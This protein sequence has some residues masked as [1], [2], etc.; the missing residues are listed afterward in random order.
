MTEKQ[1]NLIV[2]SITGIVFLAVM[3]CGILSLNTSPLAFAALFALITGLSVREFCDIVSERPDV[4]V[5]PFI[6]SVSGVCLFLAV[7]GY[8]M[9]LVTHM[10]VF[11]P[12]IISITYLLISEL[13]LQRE[14]PINNWAYTMMSQ[15]YVALPFALLPVLATLTTGEH[16]WLFPLSVFIFLW[17]SDTGAYCFGSLFGRHR[18]FERISPKKSWEGSIGG[19]IFCIIA[20]VIL[21]HFFPILNSWEWIGFALVVVVF[22]TWGDLC[23]SLIKRHWGIKDSGKILPGHGGMLDRFD[24][25][26]LAVPAVLV[27]LLLVLMVR[28]L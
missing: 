5:N 22:G 20:A 12:F 9:G 14:S 19:A 21:A 26:L 4:T 17:T 16:L 18:L 1:T 28:S 13:Y 24:S 11:V 8:S 7:Y 27:Y 2:R 3:I 6:C 15:L 23:E 10:G 25:T